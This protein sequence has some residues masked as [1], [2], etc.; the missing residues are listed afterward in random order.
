MTFTDDFVVTRLEMAN[1]STEGTPVELRDRLAN[2]VETKFKDYVEAWEIRSG[3][4]WNQMTREDAVKLV[5][6]FPEAGRNPAVISKL[7]R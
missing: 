1:L 7:Y 6:R 5:A 4:P 3:K 2:W